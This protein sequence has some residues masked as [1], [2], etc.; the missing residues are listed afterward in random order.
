ML[1]TKLLQRQQSVCG[2]P[3]ATTLRQCT[4]LQQAQGVLGLKVH[5]LAEALFSVVMPALTQTHRTQ[6]R[7]RITLQSI[8]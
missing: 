6:Q 5:H 4:Q 7:P 2:G 3:I 1:L 8:A